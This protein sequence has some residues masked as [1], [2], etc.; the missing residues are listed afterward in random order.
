MD[1]ENNFKK[2]QGLLEIVVAVGILVTGVFSAI[3]LMSTSLNAVKENEARLLGGNLAREGVEAARIMR[4]TNWLKSAPW[5]NGL[6]GLNYD[7]TGIAAFDWTNG[8]WVIDFT[9]NDIGDESAAIM[10]AGD[11][12]MLQ[13]P[14]SASLS[15][16]EST[17]YRRLIT[18]SPICE[19]G[20]VLPSGSAC[21]SKKVGVEAKSEVTW[22]VGPR[23]H[24]AVFV[25]NLY[26][27]K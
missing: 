25:E 24:K 7:Y 18:L 27:W 1:V 20:S 2:G 6:E 23:F 9:V 14:P 10:R 19:D 8:T 5:D 13:L 3:T 17:V 16:I 26:D 21:S 11:G 22:N 15:P 4:D 12:F